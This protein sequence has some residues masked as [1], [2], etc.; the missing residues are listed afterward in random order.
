MAAL[1]LSP[2]W[3]GDHMWFCSKAECVK[4]AHEHYLSSQSDLRE[5]LA[6]LNLPETLATTNLPPFP[7]V[8]ESRK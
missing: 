3:C 7:H 2:G 5:R 4:Q 1:N 8:L 6:T